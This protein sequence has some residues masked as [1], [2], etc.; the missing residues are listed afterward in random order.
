LIFG[1]NVIYML[2]GQLYY[3]WNKKKNELKTYI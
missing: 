2:I 3:Y 1:L